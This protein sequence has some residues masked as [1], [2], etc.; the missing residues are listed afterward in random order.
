MTTPPAAGADRFVFWVNRAM[1]AVKR[2]DILQLAEARLALLEI[3]LGAVAKTH[4][5]EFYGLR[6]VESYLSQEE[7]GECLTFLSTCATLET[8]ALLRLIA[9]YTKLI[10]AMPQEED[11]VVAD[12][13]ALITDIAG[14]MRATEAVT[15]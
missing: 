6:K 9:R 11:A 8:K 12:I 7:I 10:G 4:R 13:L 1:V 15:R 14:L 2:S 3:Y 5:A